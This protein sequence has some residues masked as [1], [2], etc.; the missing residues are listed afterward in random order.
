MSIDAL[1]WAWKQKTR[2]ANK[3]VLLKLADHANS[4]GWSWPSIPNIAAATGYS[5]RTVW[6]SLG[7]LE[8]EGR[9]HPQRRIKNGRFEKNRY[10]LAI[11]AD[12]GTA[13]LQRDRTEILTNDTEAAAGPVLQNSPRIK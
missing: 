12:V 3:L 11:D 8:Q 10:K 4:E 7:E 6:T 9:I 1:K 2:S 13:G 5:E